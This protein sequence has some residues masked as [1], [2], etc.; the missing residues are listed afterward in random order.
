MIKKECLTTEWI[1]SVSVR[2]KYKDLNL[3]EKV[4]R[5]MSLLEMLK[6]SGCPFCFKGGSALMLILG[7]YAHRLSIDIDIIC[8][9]GTD[10]EPYLK[11]IEKFGFISKTLEERQQR[12]THIP[13][14]HSK[15]FYHITYKNDDKLAYILLDV[16]YEDLQYHATEEVEIKG[17]FVE[18]DNEPLKVTV[19]STADIL[20]DKLT[21]FAP[22]TS[23][24]P[25]LKRDRDCSLEIIK[26]LY[27]IG[28]LFEHTLNFQH[29]KNTFTQIGKMELQY[30]G[31][32]A[33]L[34][35]IYEDIRETSLSLATKG[36][37]GKGDFK[38]LQDGIKKLD[39]YLYKEKYRIEEAIIDSAR[40]AYLATS[41]EKSNTK[42]EKYNGNPNTILT[43]ELSP[44][45]SNKLNKLKKILPE[46]F[47]YWVKT[48]ELLQK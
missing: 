20:G 5:A 3:I 21:A 11:D 25:Y 43:M 40:A 12:Y 42:I 35:L 19:P 30:R 10:I 24:I 38:M 33:E 7:E 48:S 28:R 36:Q 26:Q 17:P 16:L 37:M 39:N 34:S 4:I 31:F 47:F 9:P 44:T 32:P 1:K 15:F 18:L 22:N 46:A 41:I 13:K 6:L 8:P 27:D 2:S 45:V 23:G 29:T 14:S